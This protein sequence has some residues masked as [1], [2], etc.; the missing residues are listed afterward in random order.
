[1]IRKSFNIV[2]VIVLLLTTSGVTYHYHYCCNTL[3]A[4]SVF[5]APEPCCEHPE[6]CCSDKAVTFQLKND[7]LFG[8]DF[9]D[10]AADPIELPLAT[11]NFACIQPIEAVRPVIPEESPPPRPGLRLALLQ[12]FLI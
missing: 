2:F 12:Q 5:H 8:T 11:T 4:F 10:L 7:Y 6:D 1:M 3:M 9:I